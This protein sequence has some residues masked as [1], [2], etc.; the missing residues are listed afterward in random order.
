MIPVGDN[1]RR[2]S[3]PWVTYAI[4]LINF[5]VFVAMLRMDTGIPAGN[6]A[7]REQFI[8]Q[9][10]GECYGFQTAPTETDRFICRRAFQPREFFDTVQGDSGLSGAAERQVLL[11]PLTAA[12]MHGGWLHIL[13][14]MLF[15][16]VFAD[17]VEDR[18]GRVRFAV[19]YLFAAVVASLIQG[20]MDTSSVV[21]V[22]G[23]S[24][25]VAAVLG[26]YFVWYPR[27]TV[28]VVIPFFILIFL[29]LP[30]PAFL[31]IGLWFIQNLF[32]GYATIADAAA[33]DQGVAWFAHIGG[34]VF[35]A[36][37]A[38]LAGRA[39][40]GSRYARP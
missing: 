7:A 18:L 12:F 32:S 8:E 2:R 25:G 3:T 16:W 1:L 28:N 15:L 26:A 34:F 37:V 23:A 38:A 39:R 13:G 40:G 27:A 14:N 24:G 5:G 10:Q 17:N 22:L 4:I 29:P 31:M 6:R 36:V 11:S 30:I 33:P 21:P 20:F 19:F 9:T 35:G